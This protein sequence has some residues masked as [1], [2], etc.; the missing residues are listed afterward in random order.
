MQVISFNQLS[1]YRWVR[2]WMSPSERQ[3]EYKEHLR[4]T[5]KPESEK[6]S[7]AKNNSNGNVASEN[8]V[9]KSVEFN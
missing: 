3:L 5:R 6:K 2:N 1:G 7:D 8:P 4:S 9:L